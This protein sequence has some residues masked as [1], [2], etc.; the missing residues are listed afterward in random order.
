MHDWLPVSLGKLMKRGYQPYK[1]SYGIMF[2]FD[3]VDT[4]VTV[5]ARV[6]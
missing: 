3:I 2:T 4:K 6:T 5:V 1:C